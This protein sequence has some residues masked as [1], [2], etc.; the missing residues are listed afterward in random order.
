LP[1]FMHFH[2]TH[3]HT[4]K[5]HPNTITLSHWHTNTHQPTANTRIHDST[6]ANMRANKQKCANTHWTCSLRV[7]TSQSLLV[8]TF[9]A[10]ARPFSVFSTSA[11]AFATSSL[12]CLCIVRN[13]I[14]Q[15]LGKR[16][17]RSR[18]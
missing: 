3:T 17:P 9:L 5:A 11:L 6:F 10:S 7:E 1:Q 15:M 4:Q 14:S 16:I 13:V 18:F 8:I 2:D 12:S